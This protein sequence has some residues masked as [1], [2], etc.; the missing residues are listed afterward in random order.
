MPQRAATHATELPTG[1]N[2]IDSMRGIAT[3]NCDLDPRMICDLT[4]NEEDCYTS[5]VFDCDAISRYDFLL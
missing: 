4:E 2:G 1:T 5:S 3:S